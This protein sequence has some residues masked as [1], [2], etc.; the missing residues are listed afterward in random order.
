MIESNSQLDNTIYHGG[1][2]QTNTQA[3][4]NQEAYWLQ[5]KEKT[6]KKVS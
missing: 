5:N 1:L 2:S 4:F 3:P 6:A